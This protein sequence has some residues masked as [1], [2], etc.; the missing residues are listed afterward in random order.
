MSPSRIHNLGPRDSCYKCGNHWNA[1]ECKNT[2]AHCKLPGCTS[3]VTHTI[4]LHQSEHPK[5]QAIARRVHGDD[6][7][8]LS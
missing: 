4:Q 2:K 6:F 1:K 8:F 3:S 5:T 7:V